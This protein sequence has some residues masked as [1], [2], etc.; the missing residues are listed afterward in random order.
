MQAKD[1]PA[2]P[3]LEFLSKCT[4]MAGWHNFFPRE[5]YCPTV[6]DEMPCSTPPKVVLAKMKSLI[7]RGIVQGCCCG[8]RGDFVLKSD[9]YDLR[10]RVQQT[11]SKNEEL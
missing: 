5:E 3:I 8:C 9:P 4:Q 2:E 7:K 10:V 1:V 11:V 6:R